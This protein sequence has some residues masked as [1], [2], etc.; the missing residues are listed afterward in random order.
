MVEVKNKQQLAL[1]KHQY[2]VAVVL[3]PY[4][5]GLWLK[6]VEFRVQLYH[7][8]LEVVQ[9]MVPQINVVRKIPSSSA[10]MV[11]P[12]VALAGK[13]NP[14][15][16]SEFVAHESQVTLTSKTE[17]QES[18]HFMQSHASENSRSFLIQN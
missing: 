2:L 5:L 8:L 18:D 16:M 17:C 1:F 13:V 6:H 3:R 4:V 7:F 10:V 11:R 15:R 12:A 9:K 14:F